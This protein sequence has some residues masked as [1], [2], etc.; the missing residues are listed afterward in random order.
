MKILFVIRSPQIFH[1]YES[2][3]AAFEKRG[4]IVTLLFDKGW[5]S[6]GHIAE[7]THAFRWAVPRSGWW[8]RILFASR[9]LLSYRRYLLVK[10]QSNFYAERW[11]KYVSPKMRFFIKHVPGMHGLIKTNVLGAIL[12]FIE[13]C[14]P[15]DSSILEDIRRWAP[16]A[17]VCSPVNFR[18]SSADLEYMK[19]A[20][21]LG[22]PT[23]VPVI[24]WDNL[25]TKGI[26]HVIP[27]VVLVWNKE[28]QEEAWTHHGIS[29]E[30]TA[31]M[32]APFFD[33]WF[34]IDAPQKTKEEVLRCFGLP[35]DAGYLVYL[36][37]SD[38][39]A[40][41]ELWLI[42]KL[43]ST[44]DAAPD[45]D[46]KKIHI[47]VRPHPAHFKIYETFT[48]PSVTVWPKKGKMPKTDEALSDF[49]EMLFYS[50]AA[51]GINTSAMIDAI[52][53]GK[54]VVSV[55]EEKYTKTQM[56]AQHYRHLLSS[57]AMELSH[58][59]DEFLNILARLMR[60]EDRT[61]DARK[62]F[63]ENFVRPRG[64]DA[65]AGNMAAFEIE[66][67]VEIRAHDKK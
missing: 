25:T 60:G 1:Y 67:L 56:Q 32:G 12:R 29:K 44:L 8:R 64:L 47:I 14:V 51:V 17:V 11:L 4:H 31:I 6:A 27:D 39:I 50:V 13:H 46:V 48:M 59:S 45:P 65:L 30:H 33:K 53:A 58:S 20:K 41:N 35:A 55:V 49:H 63:V 57:N 38:N 28:Q 19:A 18:Q 37:S 24:S 23:A 52:I 15:P 5:T 21:A 26:F 10:D 66:K 61:K 42:E 36:G 16:D 3:I 2:I 54:P 7:V 9:E 40:E 22:I 62:K 34:S 43:R